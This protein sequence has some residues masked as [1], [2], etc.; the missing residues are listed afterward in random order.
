MRLEILNTGYSFGTKILF[1]IVRLFSGYPMPDAARLVFYRSD[2]YGN[3]MKKFTQQAMRGP[4]SWSVGDREL[5][6]AYIS[7]LNQC[8]FCIGAH[9][10]VATGAYADKTKVEMSLANL[11]TAPIDEKLRATLHMLKKLT[12]EHT[13]D[14]DDFRTVLAIGVTRE[15]IEDALAVCFAFNITNR[16]ADTFGFFVPEAQAMEA[17]AKYLLMRGY[18]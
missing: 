12:T 4:S 14:P 7:K 6:A 9:V 13:I 8:T 15:Q 17:G 16:L 3:P 18:K 10:A 2:F 5:M 11:E 1:R